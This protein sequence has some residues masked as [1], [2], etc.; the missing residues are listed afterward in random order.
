MKIELIKEEKYGDQDWYCVIV[1]GMAVAFEH[2][3]EKADELYQMLINDPNLLE[4]RKIIL[5]SVEI[6]V[7]LE[8]TKTQ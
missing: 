5:K 1:D 7:P 4:K 2:T 3:E 8:D 6:V